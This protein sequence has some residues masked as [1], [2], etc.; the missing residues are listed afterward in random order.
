MATNTNTSRKQ[1]DM[2]TKRRVVEQVLSRRLPLDKACQEYDLQPYQLMAWIGQVQLADPS[3]KP[4]DAANT[5]E[6][7]KLVSHY[8]SSVT[9]ASNGSA[10]QLSPE[11]EV[12]LVV[13]R[14]YLNT[15]VA[16]KPSSH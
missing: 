14:W 6:A 3:A 1:W 10:V 2:D 8:S 12:A 11:D 16:V 7:A 15:K 4:T 5:I 13:G 9:A